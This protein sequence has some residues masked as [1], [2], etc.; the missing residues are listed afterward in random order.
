MRFISLASFAFLCL[1]C[2]CGSNGPKLYPVQGIVQ[3]ADGKVV[4]GGSIEF[5]LISKQPV[6]ASGEIG[7]D[8]S[9][10][11]GTRALDDGAQAGKHRVVVFSDY[12]IGNGAE[13]PGLIPVTQVHPKHRD[14]DDSGIEIEVK[15]ENNTVIIQVDYAPKLDDESPDE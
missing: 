13:R 6:V 15:P 8:G 3:F 2:G 1:L 14:Y 4:R 5:E 7:P 11:L 9:F 10:V 12:Q